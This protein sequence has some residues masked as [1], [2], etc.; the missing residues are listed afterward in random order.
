MTNDSGQLR[1]TTMSNK[2]LC[3][4]INNKLDKLNEL[5]GDANLSGVTIILEAV[6]KML[7]DIA[8]DAYC[9]MLYEE[10]LND[11]SP[12]KHESI[13]LEELADELGITLA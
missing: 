9:T 3:M 11:D 5:D 1:I 7:D 8:E 12:D 10:Y 6:I 4:S 13:T 2:E